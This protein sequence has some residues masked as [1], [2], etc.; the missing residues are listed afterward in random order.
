[1]IVLKWMGLIIWLSLGILN[2]C[3]EGEINKFQYGLCWALL[4]MYLI[5]GLIK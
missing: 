3:G 2:L 5:G 4:I 1:M